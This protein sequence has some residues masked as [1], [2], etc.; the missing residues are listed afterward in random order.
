MRSSDLN[1][2]MPN[3]TRLNPLGENVIQDSLEEEIK[4]EDGDAF[5][6]WIFLIGMLTPIFAYVLFLVQGTTQED[7]Q[8]RAKVIETQILDNL[9]K[10]DKNSEKSNQESYTKI[11]DIEEIKS[12]IQKINTAK[13]HN[14]IEGLLRKT[15]HRKNNR[16]IIN[17]WGAEWLTNPLSGFQ[18]QAVTAQFSN[19]SRSESIRY[20][21]VSG[22]RSDFSEYLAYFV[23]QDNSLAL[24]WQAT[25]GWSEFLFD[26]LIQRKPRGVVTVRCL[27]TKK[28]GYEILLK[29]TKYSGYLISSPNLDAYT[30]A[31]VPLKTHQQVDR[32][33][34]HALNYGS[35][36]TKEPPIED[37]RVTLKISYQEELG[38]EGNFI[39]TEFLHDD[40]VTPKDPEFDKGKG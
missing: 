18:W 36:T 4:S 2:L 6:V 35:F 17:E 29:G 39:I 23:Y 1:F 13:F 31:Y 15:I 14:E 27:L 25:I 30:F 21:K 5:W 22:R 9:D 20:L 12:I 34:R 26:E 24:D 19:Q 16:S 10:I 28:P 7:E 32:N 38:K 3:Q 8:Q 33:L 40:W 11:E 37:K